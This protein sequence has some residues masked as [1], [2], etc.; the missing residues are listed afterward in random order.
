MSENTPEQMSDGDEN[1]D[2]NV[3]GEVAPSGVDPS[4][5]DED[6]NVAEIQGTLPP[7]G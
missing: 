2:L 5:Q 7:V 1:K 6:E 4:V 3:S